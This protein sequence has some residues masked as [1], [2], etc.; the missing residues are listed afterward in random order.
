M[1]SPPP[2]ESP[3]RILSRPLTLPCG[4]VL[5]NRIMKSATSEALGTRDNRPTP[6]LARLYRTLAEGGPGLIITGNVMLD[7]RRLGEPRNVVIED[8]S[9][10]ALLSDWA[11][12]GT[13]GGGHLWM[14]INHPG[15]QVPRG[16]S[17]ETVG[18][19]AVAFSPAMRRFFPTPRALRTDEIE[20]I[21]ARFSKSAKIAK[22]AGFTGVQVHGAHGYLVSQFLSPR[23]NI[24]EDEWGGNPENR[25]RFL[26]R[27]CR[28]L[29]EA[30]GPNFPVAVKLNS[31]DFQHGGFSDQDAIAVAQALEAEGVDL[32]EISGGS[33]ESP[34]MTGRLSPEGDRQRE[35]Y[36]LD[37]AQRLRDAVRL[38]LALTGGFRTGRG[39]ARAVAEGHI[40]VAGL[41]RPLIIDPN[42]PKKILAGEDYESPVAP[43]RTGFGP[44][45]RAAMME[46]AWYELQ[47]ARMAKGKAPKTRENPWLGFAKILARNGLHT[48]ALRRARE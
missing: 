17:P 34:A 33:Y 40:D 19:S 24:R 35:A 1:T 12:A 41:A 8:E 10:L 45:D 38:P 13:G 47:L 26:L 36:F 3:A 39:M 43:I 21:I 9:D 20:D 4:Q 16:L 15:R 18:P 27:I 23:T 7:R 32:L 28:G 2:E 25:M 31:A 44:L 5:P 22:K 42:M 29:R 48:F 30:L 14:Q 37:F 6:G 46:V 11:R